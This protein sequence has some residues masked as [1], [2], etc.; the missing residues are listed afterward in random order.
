MN[1]VFLIKKK[2]KNL[3]YCSLVKV[4]NIEWDDRLYRG[5]KLRQWPFKG[6]G[7]KKIELLSFADWCSTN[8]FQSNK[9][10]SGIKLVNHGFSDVI[11]STEYCGEKSN[12]TYAL[13]SFEIKAKEGK[14]L[15]YPEMKDLPDESITLRVNIEYS[16][17]GGV[18]LYFLNFE[19]PNW[20]SYISKFNSTGVEIG[21]GP[22]P[23]VFGKNIKYLEKDIKAKERLQLK[24]DLKIS[25]DDYIVGP[26]H[27][28]PVDDGTLDFIFSSHV[29]EHLYNPLGHLK[30]WCSKLKK[31]GKVAG[32]VPSA[33]GC[34]D[35]Y[36]KPSSLEILIKEYDEGSFETAR[37]CYDYYAEIRRWGKN[38]A[39][40]MYAKKDP[41]IH[42]HFYNEENMTNLLKRAIQDL[43]Y[44]NFFIDFQKNRKDFYF[45]LIK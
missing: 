14:T 41:S 1:F 7:R 23:K 11:I 8:E 18:K 3:S 19:S 5:L 20:S 39:D 16:E 44:S 30:L 6:F 42:V 4:A 29:F 12:K 2:I 43:G 28:L 31:G 33:Y 24:E 38:K 22:Y 37:R 45:E 25:L 32:V 10:D 36:A 27:E 13:E 15:F 17:F 9:T 21:P 40:E 35:F 26:A 34:K